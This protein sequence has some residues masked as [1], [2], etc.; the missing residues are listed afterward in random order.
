[1]DNTL[2][3]SLLFDFYGQLLTARQRDIYEMHFAQDLSLGEIGEQL[4]I[5][6]QA[7]YDIVKRAL[8][9]ME[10]FETKLE[11]IS[12]YNNQQRMFNQGEN[13]ILKLQNLIENEDTMV[14]QC[15]QITEILKW[16]EEI[17]SIG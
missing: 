2:R 8:R 6:R 15:R 9:I 5:S 16:L 14:E 10:D 12:K 4:E 3:R 1:M 13:L 17:R 7:V 11:L